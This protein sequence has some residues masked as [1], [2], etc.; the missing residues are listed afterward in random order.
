VGI[1]VNKVVFSRINLFYAWFILI[2]L[3]LRPEVEI[4]EEG[5]RC[6][7]D[8]I[9][10]KPNDLVVVL[11][12]ALGQYHAKYLFLAND[13]VFILCFYASGLLPNDQYV[14]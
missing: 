9:W 4:Y 1:V 13:E 10:Y 2:C 7:V 12:A 5:S 3:V 14:D 11:D 6:N 8:G